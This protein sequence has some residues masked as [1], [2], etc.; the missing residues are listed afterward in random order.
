MAGQNPIL[1]AMPWT[2]DPKE[3][4]RVVNGFSEIWT[5]F[6]ATKTPPRFGTVKHPRHDADASGSVCV[7]A[8]IVNG[9]GVWLGAVAYIDDKWVLR[10][11]PLILKIDRARG[12][13]GG[14]A[15]TLQVDAGGRMITVRI[16]EISLPIGGVYNSKL[17][18]R[19]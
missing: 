2:T 9:G 7:V 10:A 1:E 13:M 8:P 12:T 19:A 16:D 3:C 18:R 4:C 6:P 11:K 17:T 5:R 14:S 15:P